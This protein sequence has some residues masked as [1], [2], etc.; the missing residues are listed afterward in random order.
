MRQLIQGGVSGAEKS[1]PP[2][3]TEACSSVR[4]KVDVLVP[5][6]LE[7]GGQDGENKCL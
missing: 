6:G 3:L 7:E 4:E 2:L 5:V 1:P